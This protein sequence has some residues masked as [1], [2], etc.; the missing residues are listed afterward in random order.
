MSLLGHSGYSGT[1]IQASVSFYKLME[2][3]ESSNSGEERNLLLDL[4]L[5]LDR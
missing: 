5:D 2:S 3:V 1:F 4:D